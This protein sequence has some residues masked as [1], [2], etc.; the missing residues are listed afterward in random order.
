MEPE[1]ATVSV[2]QYETTICSLTDEEVSA[3][4]DTDVLGHVAG[5]N[6]ISEAERGV[7]YL[8][9][10]GGYDCDASL[11]YSYSYMSPL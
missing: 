4:T 7:S 5:V 2:E 1:S 6:P 9:R 8:L 3:F 11:R 10:Q